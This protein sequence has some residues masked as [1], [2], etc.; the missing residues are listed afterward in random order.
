MDVNWTYSTYFAIY[1]NIK[2]VCCTRETN[3][4]LYV[5]CA[6]VMESSILDSDVGRVGL[7]QVL[8]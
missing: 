5:S 2:S 3:I 7:R 6:S 8:G 1:T 4:M